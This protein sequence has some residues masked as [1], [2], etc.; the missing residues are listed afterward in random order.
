MIT[1]ALV[2]TTTTPYYYRLA[3]PQYVDGKLVD[4]KSNQGR[5][6]GFWELNGATVVGVSP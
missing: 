6:N 4:R 2:K 5:T 1:G 3:A